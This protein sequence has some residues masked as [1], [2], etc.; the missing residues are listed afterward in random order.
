MGNSMIYAMVATAAVLWGANF[1]LAKQVIV[2]LHPLAAGAGRFLIAALIMLLIVR[3]RGERVPLLR[4]WRAYAALGLVGVGGFN[5]LF[6]FGMQST[7]AVNGA[8]IM[9]LNPLLTAL[10]AYPLLGERPSS[11]QLLA[12]PLGLGGVAVVVLG[13]AAQQLRI[14]PG[15][16]MMLG[17]NLCWAGYNVLGRRLMPAHT[18]GLANTAGIMVA[19]ALVLVF[20]AGVA[21]APLALPGAP[22]GGALLLMALGGSV[23]AYLFW[24]VGLARLGAGRTALF[25]NLVPVSSMAIAALSGTPP[26]S[27]QL[28]GGA[29]VMGAVS[30]AMWPARRPLAL[31]AD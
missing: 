26:S 25:L 16:L 3:L 13:G 10:L 30:L 7:S 15:D 9:A 22:A 14:A 1:N 17:A 29:V 19:G 11:R 12:F 31:A 28:L 21:G 2:D 27:A 24:N 18:S 20:A 4:H 23:L 8:L 5:L 6:F